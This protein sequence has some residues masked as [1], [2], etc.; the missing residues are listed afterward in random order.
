M[1]NLKPTG[2]VITQ[3]KANI[4]LCWLFNACNRKFEAN[5]GDVGMT[6]RARGGGGLLQGCSEARL[7]ILYPLDECTVYDLFSS[8]RHIMS[9]QQ[10]QPPPMETTLYVASVSS[11]QTGHSCIAKSILLPESNSSSFYTQI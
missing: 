1:N 9:Q 2:K 8:R 10:S 6:G 5:C 4:S 7:R 3:R 11:T